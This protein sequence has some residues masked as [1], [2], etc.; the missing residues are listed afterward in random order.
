MITIYDWFGYEVSMKERYKLIK[1]AGF[2]GVLLWWSEHFGRGDYRSGP[3]LAREAGLVIENIHAPIHNEHDLWTD[4]LNGESVT[5]SYLQCIVDCNEYEIPTMVVH[6]PSED[7]PYNTLGVERMKRITAQAEQF[8]VNVAFENLRNFTNLSQVLDQV[9][10]K[11]IGFCYDCGHH[12]R[13]YPGK[14]LLSMYGSRLMA[15][16]L[17]DDN[18]SREQHGLPFD[19]SIDWVT[20]MNQIAGTGYTGATALEPMNWDYEEL[21][22]RA[23]LEKAFVKAQQLEAIRLSVSYK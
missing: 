14:D 21:S 10:S 13:Y 18:G 22:I 17:H 16:H 2:D 8:N 12:Y 1:E 15:V 20:T 19:G 6:L 9:D 4:N 5:N 11:R 3:Q 7:H 23:F